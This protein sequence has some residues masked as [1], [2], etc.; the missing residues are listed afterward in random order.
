MGLLD[1]LLGGTIGA[2][3]V[4]A[5]N[6]LIEK[7]GGLAGLAKTFQ[8]KGLAPIVQSWISTGENQPIA[9]EQVGQAVGPDLI[10]ELAAKAG[11][12]PEELKKKL[13]EILPN[14]VDKLTPE[15]K[16]PS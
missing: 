3:L 11:V 5:A 8:E 4:T 16:L 14:A 2:A 10:A 13:A 15:G 6:E 7:H 9:P 1:G 12:T